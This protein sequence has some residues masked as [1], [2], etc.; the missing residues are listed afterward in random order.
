MESKQKNHIAFVLLCVGIAA[1]IVLNLLSQMWSAHVAGRDATPY[2]ATLISLAEPECSTATKNNTCTLAAVAR[3]TLPSGM[4]EQAVFAG[5]FF[6]YGDA[7]RARAA[8]VVDAPTKVYQLASPRDGRQLYTAAAFEQLRDE[9]TPRGNIPALLSAAIFILFGAGSL[10]FSA[11][12]ALQR[13]N[14]ERERD[15]G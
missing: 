13:R 2:P 5:S 8:L 12:G 4:S 3:V 11:I 10:L 15:A 14:A 9:S 1:A 7:A 6:G